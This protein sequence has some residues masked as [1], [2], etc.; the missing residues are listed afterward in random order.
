[1]KPLLTP[2]EER[3][4]IR[5]YSWREIYKELYRRQKERILEELERRKDVKAKV[6]FLEDLFNATDANVER[7]K[8][9][10]FYEEELRDFIREKLKEV[11][12][13][14]EHGRR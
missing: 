7:L 3:R 4:F 9:E 1:M 14:Q 13:A 11:E 2:Y 6:W 5:M 12:E 8:D 10:L